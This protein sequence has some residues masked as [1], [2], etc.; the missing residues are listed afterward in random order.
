MPNWNFKFT[1]EYDNIGRVVKAVNENGGKMISS[2][3]EDDGNETTKS[4]KTIPIIREKDGITQRERIY[5]FLKKNGA[6][7]TS[8]IE[9][10]FKRIGLNPRSVSPA[11]SKLRDEDKK[12]TRDEETGLWKAI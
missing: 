10:E 6:M 3:A 4:K 2:F 1:M 11:L 5:T 8:V 7:F 9:A 12:V